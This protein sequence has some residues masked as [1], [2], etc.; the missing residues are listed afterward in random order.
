VTQQ[1]P[2]AEL[3]LA[4]GGVE[5]RTPFLGEME[6]YRVLEAGHHSDHSHHDYHPAVVVGRQRKEVVD[7]DPVVEELDTWHR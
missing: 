2:P 4:L 6:S 5:M 1:A 3:E 7:K